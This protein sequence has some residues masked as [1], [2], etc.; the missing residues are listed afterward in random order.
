MYP[1]TLGFDE[2]TARITLLL[3]NGHQAEALLTT[4]F[5]A[6]KML[7]R[8][9]RV[10]AVCSGLTSKQTT[11]LIGRGGFDRLKELWTV[12]SPN[13]R[14]LPQLFG[15]A[16]GSVQTGKRMRNDLVH[17]V[18]AYPLADCEEKAR[19]ILAGL[20]SF[21]RELVKE[22]GHDGWARLP[23]RRKSA[24]TWQPPASMT[25]SKPS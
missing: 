21:R 24:L 17:G 23:T 10:A 12:F 20:A 13:A 3:D 11:V 19:E 4:V 25:T 9:V 16:W 1:T 2:A 7:L 5:T 18:R 22:I 14:T 6:E 15:P 8:A